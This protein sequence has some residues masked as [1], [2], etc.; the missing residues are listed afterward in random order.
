MSFADA[1]SKA[2]PGVQ[3]RPG[4]ALAAPEPTGAAMPVRALQPHI[5]L[6]GRRN[7]GKSSLLNYLMGYDL[8]L[9]SPVPGTTTD[10]VEK[11]IEL[12]GL[13]PVTLVDTPG[14]DDAGELGRMRAQKGLERMAFVH[15]AL[16][17]TDGAWGKP[18]KETLAA[19]HERGTPCIIVRTKAD[20]ADNP[21][22]S[23]PGS[24][25]GSEPGSEAEAV[26]NAVAD[27]VAAS[28]APG[29]ECVSVSAKARTGLQDLLGAIRR[30]LP[31]AALVPPPLLRDLLAPGS[32]C[33][34]VA[35]IDASA[36]K[37]RLIAP[38]TQALRD[39]LDGHIICLVLQP[40]ELAGALG[41]LAMPPA[42]VVCDSQV[43]R[44]CG[45]AL[46]PDAPLTTFSILMARQKADLATLCAGA[47]AIYSLQ[48]NDKV[49]ISEVCAHHAQPDDIGR[50]KIPAML[51]AFTGKNLD[52]RFSSGRD[53]PENLA[54]FS[55]VIHCG[56]C[57]IAPPLMH[58][59]MEAARSAGVPI[60][61]YGVAIS[62]MQGILDRSLHMFPD[63][64]EAFNAKT[65]RSS[66]NVA[67]D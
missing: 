45:D 14:L 43:V 52:I 48:D 34:L 59:R 21:A 44:A 46:P 9:V 27:A 24:G 39:C 64:L 20:L 12:P 55:L 11:S 51:R 42:L 25:P 35:P 29:V 58:A 61:N 17:V 50:V 54:E 47:A 65:E 8:A 4:A 26:P 49:C 62:L 36:P 66:P 30:A 67:T 22:D 37:G 60:T 5:G 33:V 32:L 16:L 23:A 57:M 41:R 2:A 31:E 13:G 7:A 1:A 40:E 18:E 56:G 3:A 53:Y 28:S 15:L 10:P 6:F 19:L 38:Q 63:A